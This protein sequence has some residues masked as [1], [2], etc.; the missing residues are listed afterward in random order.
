MQKLKTFR[1]FG[2]GNINYVP[3]GM[4]VYNWVELEGSFHRIDLTRIVKIMEEAPLSH[5]PDN[6]WCESCDTYVMNHAHDTE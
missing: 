4:G 5:D 6:V 3:D 2:K 1:L